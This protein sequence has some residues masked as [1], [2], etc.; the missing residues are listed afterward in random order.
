MEDRELLELAKSMDWLWYNNDG[1][2]EAD[3]LDA[4]IAAVAKLARAIVTA[5]GGQ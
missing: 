5:R 1:L 2:S 4:V 3:R